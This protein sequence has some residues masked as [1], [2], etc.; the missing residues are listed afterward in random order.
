MRDEEKLLGMVGIA[1]RAGVLTMGFDSVIEKMKVGKTAC[2][3]ITADCSPKT[4]KEVRFFGDK[5]KIKV[6]ELPLEMDALK[7]LF[8]KR[9]GVM[10]VEQE[11]LA[12]R[13]ETLSKEADEEDANDNKI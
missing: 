9:V 11:A 8:G 1:R 3:F 12:N 4:K 10:A 6:V 13:I 5:Y 2:A 7:A